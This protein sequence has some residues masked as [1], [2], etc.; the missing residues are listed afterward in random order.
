MYCGFVDDVIFSH[1][2]Q[3]GRPLS[4]WLLTWPCPGK[5]V[6]NWMQCWLA[7]R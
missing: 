5:T 4:L 7:I 2:G 6:K 3:T 1:N